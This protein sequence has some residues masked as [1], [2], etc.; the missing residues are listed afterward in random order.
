VIQPQTSRA[1]TPTSDGLASW[2]TPGLV[3]GFGDRLL[4]FDNTETD[5]LELLRF[6]PSLTAIDGFEDALHER[7]RQVGRLPDHA[8]PLIVAVE[9]L[10]GDGAL[11]LV[12]THTAG[13][14]LSSFFDKPGP[15]RG[16]NPAFVTGIVTQVIQAL[17]VLQSK[18]EDVTHGALTADRVVV[19]TGGR[20]RVVEHVL[21]L[22]LRKLS[23]SGSQLWREFGLIT[24]PVPAGATQTAPVTLDARTDVFQLGVLA[25]ELLLGRRLSPLDLKDRLPDLLDQWSNAAARAGLATARLR[26]WLERALQVGSRSYTTAADAYSDLRDMPSESTASAFESLPMSDVDL[27]GGSFRSL[28]PVR[29]ATGQEP[30][31]A[32]ATAPDNFPL[33][34]TP[35]PARGFDAAPAKPLESAQ[36]RPFDAAHGNAALVPAE[37]GW[38]AFVPEVKPAPAPA[39]AKE[40]TPQQAEHAQGVPAATRRVSPHAAASPSTAHVSTR[41]AAAANP[42][43]KRRMTFKVPSVSP[44][45]AAALGL[46]S[47]VEGGV[48]A[49]LMM[50]QPASAAPVAPAA[51][52]LPILD[53]V[54]RSA[55]TSPIVPAVA[56]AVPEQKP[57]VLAD[58]IDP[59]TA[60]AS[61]QRSGGIKFQTPIELKVLQ[62]DKVFGSTG[63]GPIIAPEGT[64]QVDLVNAAYGVRISRPLTFRAGQIANLSVTIP[65]GRLSVNAQPWAEIS[66]DGQAK[67]DTPLANLSVSVG[68]HEIVYRHPELGERRQTVIVRADQPARASVSFDK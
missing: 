54:S 8:F 27:T 66:L 64:Y 32:N 42:A 13:K 63:D 4:M 17:T 47:L 61:K 57:A 56:T 55:T 25:M 40:S 15:R 65:P 59:I 19:T 3:D 31:M 28:L 41:K 50:R 14:R 48:I 9:R 62:G 23:L 49:A 7:V 6:Y 53:T 36:A 16:L 29:R 39:L 5:S 44:W 22:A 34:N 68:Q 37:R 26:V 11:A 20:I 24:A 52:S 46:V 58:A 45:I 51:V 18:G 38:D 12:S 30:L 43:S 67:G 2:Y 10:E 33:I 1:T 35:Q 21:G 60:A